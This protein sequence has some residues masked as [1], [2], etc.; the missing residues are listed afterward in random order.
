MR[1]GQPRP[2]ARADVEDQNRGVGI[3]RFG[4]RKTAQREGAIEGQAR[5]QGL[6]PARSAA[7]KKDRL[8]DGIDAHDFLFASGVEIA[9]EPIHDRI[10]PVTRVSKVNIVT[11]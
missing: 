9:S 5:E 4:K 10:E 11:D 3:G 7:R 1:V 2:A 6:V 8:F